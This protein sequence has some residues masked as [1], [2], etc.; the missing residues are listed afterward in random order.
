MK[1]VVSRM[2]LVPLSGAGL[3]TLQ[4]DGEPLGRREDA[5]DDAT[6]PLAAHLQATDRITYM[7]MCMCMCMHMCTWHVHVTC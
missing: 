4:R 3:P 6:G 2:N 1:V 5:R 7:C